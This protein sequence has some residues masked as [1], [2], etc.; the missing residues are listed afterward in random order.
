MA[1][2]KGETAAEHARAIERSDMEPAVEQPAPGEVAY[3]SFGIWEKRLIVFTASLASNFSPMSTNI[4]FPA[5]NSVSTD[6]HVSV[7]EINLT[8]TTY[9]VSTSYSWDGLIKITHISSRSCRV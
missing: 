2:P 4:Y 9:L 3:S 6:L 7:S 1:R 5:L 8:V